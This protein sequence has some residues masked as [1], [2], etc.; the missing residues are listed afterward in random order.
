MKRRYDVFTVIFVV[1]LLIG[2]QAVEVA[3]ASNPLC[4]T[5]IKSPTNSTYD[6]GWIDLE[7][8]TVG[9]SGSNIYYSTSYSVDGKDNVTL[10]FTTEPYQGSF[11]IS[12]KG[13]VALP[14]LSEGS[15]SI[16]VYQK[17]EAKSTPPE[18]YWDI[19]SVNFS[20]AQQ[21]QS[22]PLITP[23]VTNE[24]KLS[25]YVSHSLV[26]IAIASIIVIVAVASILLVYLKRRRGKS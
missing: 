5:V 8:L 15:H 3:K 26:P 24:L 23:S 19:Y 1:S 17:V 13:L 16:I 12:M 14:L 11:Q 9:L 25:N 2:T 22:S 20:V 10:P 6:T 18:T 7:T 4:S 21:T